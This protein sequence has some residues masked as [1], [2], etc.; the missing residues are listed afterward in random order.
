MKPRKV[1]RAFA[2]G[3][4]GSVSRAIGL[5]LAT[6]I[7]WGGGSA[8]AETSV[9]NPAILFKGLYSAEMSNTPHKTINFAIND[10][11]GVVVAR[12]DRADAH[13]ARAI[14]TVHQTPI[15][16]TAIL[17]PVDG[18]FTSGRDPVSGVPFATVSIGLGNED[19]SVTYVFRI[20]PR[21][22]GDLRSLQLLDAVVLIHDRVDRRTTPRRFA[23]DLQRK[24]SLNAS[25][26]TIKQL[27]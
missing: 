21:V 9:G 6:L 7:G 10:R 12:V 4:Q 11:G 22:D 26:E 24:T 16:N 18:D 1:T 17:S 15:A 2:E 8:R 14:M 23:V 25:P 3:F 13:G 5:A 20:F 19:R 27:N